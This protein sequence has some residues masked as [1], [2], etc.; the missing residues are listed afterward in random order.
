MNGFI[1]TKKLFVQKILILYACFTL[2][3]HVKSLSGV[4]SFHVGNH[5]RLV[6]MLSISF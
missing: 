6:K 3:A 4:A 2:H 5:S 1:F